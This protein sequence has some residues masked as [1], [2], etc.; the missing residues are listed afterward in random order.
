VATD[1]NT[2]VPPAAGTLRS[3]VI[4][5]SHSLRLSPLAPRGSRLFARPEGADPTSN[6]TITN[7]TVTAY[8]KN[9]ITCDDMGTTCAIKD[10]TVTGIGPTT[11]IAQNGIQG[12]GAS[13]MT[14][15]SDIVT[16]NTYTGGY[17]AASGLLLIDSGTLSVAT[18]TASSNDYNMY[19]LQD[20]A[21]N[22]VAGT[23][24]VSGSTAT[25][26]TLADGIAVDSTSNSVTISGNRH[27]NGNANNGISLYGTTGV[28]LSDNGASSNAYD[29]I[30]VG[31]PGTLGNG[32]T[33]NMVSGNTTSSNSNDGIL[34]DTDATSNTM[35]GNH[36][37]TNIV[38]DYQD[39]GTNNWT[40]NTCSPHH[41]SSPGGIC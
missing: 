15:T 8:D 28:S 21:A 25:N 1:S 35:T 6:V 39:L 37:A 4:P 34:A 13:S 33:L 17:Y 27:V 32:S 23:W 18:S 36:A 10:T 16:D 12:Y 7:V 30:Y 29:G 24:S 41:D 22:T 19:L 40:S 31:G 14:L 3:H 20:N 26:S 2:F 38:Y 11:L 9:G 5:G